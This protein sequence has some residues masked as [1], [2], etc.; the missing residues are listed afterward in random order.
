MSTETQVVSQPSPTAVLSTGEFRLLNPV[1][2]DE[3]SYG[4][5][6]FEWQW[7][8]SLAENQ[9]FEVRVWQTGEPPSGVHDA[10]LDNRQGKIEAVGNQTYRLVVDITEA[11]GVRQR[12][13]EFNWTVVLVQIDPDYKDL[14]FQASPAHLRFEPP[15]ASGG[16]G[17][18][19]G[20][21]G[22]FN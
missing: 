18:N 14:G 11:P 3:P 7:S 8:G 6:E 17:G 20:G 12:R 15:G 19:D 13:G 1:S 21:G 4:L 9:G 5:T 16:G 2:L 22:A 10:V